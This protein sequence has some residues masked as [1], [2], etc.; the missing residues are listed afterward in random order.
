MVNN[1]KYMQ[2]P[3]EQEF[4]LLDIELSQGVTVQKLYLVAQKYK[5][6]SQA[7]PLG[8]SE[9]DKAMSGGIRASELIVVSGQTGQGKT[10]F[11]QTLTMNLAKQDVNSIWFSYEMSPDYLEE[12]F[13]EMGYEPCHGVFAP[14]QLVDGTLQFLAMEIEEARKTRDCRV[15]FIDHLHYLIPLADKNNSSLVI[16][17][18]VRGLKQLAIK[19]RITIFLIAHTK[20][21]YQGEEMDLSSVRD[22]SLV[23]QEADFVFLVERQKFITEKPKVK[24]NQWGK[25]EVIIPFKPYG[26][27]WSNNTKVYLAKNRRTGKLMYL[28]FQYINGVLAP[29]TTT[30]G[31]Q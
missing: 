7:I 12:K 10:L 9:F 8:V 2:F 18:I 20:K 22:S 16:G 29:C 4:T 19:Y 14:V 24:N 17:A 11:C 31:Q 1:K 21:I 30:Y 3:N 26:S 25:D 23:C 6:T 15:V 5:D 13:R 27:E 28:F